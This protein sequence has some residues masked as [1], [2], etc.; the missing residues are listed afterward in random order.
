[1]IFVFNSHSNNVPILCTQRYKHS[2]MR[3]IIRIHPIALFILIYGIATIYVP[4][5]S[6]IW[7]WA[8]IISF[9]SKLTC[10]W[11]PIL[12]GLCT[13]ICN[14]FHHPFSNICCLHLAGI[15]R[16]EAGIKM[17]FKHTNRSKVI[18]SVSSS[19]SLIRQ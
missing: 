4:E 2:I 8:S 10:H 15:I 18:K 12:I 1:M 7:S 9:I 3:L 19:L 11:G 14:D 17:K 5:G 16:Y 13:S 6:I